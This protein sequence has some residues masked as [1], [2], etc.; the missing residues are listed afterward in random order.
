M[1]VIGII[2][3]CGGII[4][5]VAWLLNR[6]ERPEGSGRGPGAGRI[7]YGMETGI[8]GRMKKAKWKSRE[9][10]NDY[11][12]AECSGC[13]FQVESYDAVETGRSSTEYIKAKWKFCPKCEL[14]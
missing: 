1:A 14:K 4:C 6:A 9:E 5:A 8:M 7:S 11:I 2:V 13:G 3:F 12:H 10:H